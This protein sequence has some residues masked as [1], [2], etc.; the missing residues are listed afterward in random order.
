MKKLILLT[1]LAIFM[2]LLA[3]P[4]GEPFTQVIINTKP[5]GTV[6][7]YRLMHPYEIIYARDTHLYITEKVGRVV[8]VDPATGLRQII[9]DYRANTFLNISRD[10]TGAATSIG[11]DGM[12]GMA[13]HPN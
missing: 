8:R 12:L 9:L 1:C 10:G 5:A 7:D 11:Q 3:R 2:F 6:N 13:M 4:Q